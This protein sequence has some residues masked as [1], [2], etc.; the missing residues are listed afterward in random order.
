[1]AILALSV[2]FIQFNEND[3]TASVDSINYYKHR[4]LGLHVI[5]SSFGEMACR[6]WKDWCF[7]VRRTV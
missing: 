3:L 2:G 7:F 5:S 1:M 6:G 4:L